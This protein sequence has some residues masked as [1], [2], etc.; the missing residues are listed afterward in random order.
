MSQ[1][2]LAQVNIGR[3]R[4]P[5]EDPR[6]AGF[7]SRLEDLNALADRSPGFVWRL[8]TPA[9]D[10]TYFRPYQHDDRIL[11]NM[12]VWESFESLKHYVYRTA[13]AE[14]L[15]HRHEWFELFSGSYLALWWVPVG[16]RPGLDEATKRLA[17]LERNGPTQF[18]FNFKTVFP[19]DEDFQRTI[20]WSSFQPCPAT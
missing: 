1:Y 17:H 4:A 20:D 9:G 2:H 19:P 6:M 8:Q 11:I 10:A 12:S 18:A 5:L 14:L 13:H 7:V 16:H 15:R 3:V